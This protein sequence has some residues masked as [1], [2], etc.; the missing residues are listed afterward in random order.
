MAR[1]LVRSL[2]EVYTTIPRSVL[3]I[4]PSLRQGRDTARLMLLCLAV[5]ESLCPTPLFLKDMSVA[6]ACCLQTIAPSFPVE[7]SDLSICEG[8]LVRKPREC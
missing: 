7:G 4:W 5:G 3:L 8:P 1:L 6:V 2:G